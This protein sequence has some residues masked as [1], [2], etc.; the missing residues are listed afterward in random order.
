[1]DFQE[2][3]AQIQPKMYENESRIQ[4]AKKVISVI[5][6]SIGETKDKQLLDIGCSTGIMTG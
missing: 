2:D 1:M 3:Y 4:K 6:D 5:R